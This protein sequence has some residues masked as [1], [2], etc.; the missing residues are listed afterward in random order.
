MKVR[1]IP[2]PLL[3]VESTW[4]KL[5]GAS[6]HRS[7]CHVEH[8]SQVLDKTLSKRRMI[9]SASDR[10][11]TRLNLSQ[12]YEL[13]ASE[14]GSRLSNSAAVRRMRACFN[15]SDC[16]VSLGAV[17][18]LRRFIKL[19]SS[20]CAIASISAEAQSVSGYTPSVMS[21]PSMLK[22][23]VATYFHLVHFTLKLLILVLRCPVSVSRSSLHVYL[24][25][26]SK[27]V[28]TGT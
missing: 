19:Y 8:W 7:R 10:Q 14:C 18:R 13:T 16:A 23:I 2:S 1:L 26:V 9:S 5:V 21:E 25:D 17:E 27:S 24:P 15:D 4:S 20:R 12:R 11:R 22:Y 3:T 6:W 28:F